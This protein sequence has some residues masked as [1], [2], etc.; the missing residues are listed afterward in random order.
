LIEDLK[1]TDYVAFAQL[2]E[3]TAC[4]P[5]FLDTFTEICRAGA[6]FTRFLTQAV[7]LAF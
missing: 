4:S 7:G 5:G 6:P 1:R 2:D 3:K